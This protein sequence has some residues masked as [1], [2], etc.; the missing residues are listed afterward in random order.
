M[1]RT[2]PSP[3]QGPSPPDRDTG[4]TQALLGLL[5]ARHWS[6]LLAS[7]GLVDRDIKKH[8]RLNSLRFLHPAV[9]TE[10]YVSR[11][12]FPSPKMSSRSFLEALNG[13]GLE[14]T[15]I[16]FKGNLRQMGADL[17][18]PPRSLPSCSPFPLPR[19]G[20]GA[21]DTEGIQ[22]S[23][24]ALAKACLPDVPFPHSPGLRQ[25]ASARL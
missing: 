17:P 20:L 12:F 4:E 3:S 15:F 14:D 16:P 10:N 2:H 24:R 9:S 18:S 25:A 8:Q 6:P 7:P 21:P 22:G 19:G 11:F 13:R 23:T 5:G 1:R